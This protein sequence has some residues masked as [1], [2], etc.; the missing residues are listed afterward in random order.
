MRHH[1][2]PQELSPALEK[3]DEFIQQILANLHILDQS[4]HDEE[5][6]VN[7]SLLHQRLN[8]LGN[9]F[10]DI[11]FDEFAS[12]QKISQGQAHQTNEQLRI[13]EHAIVQKQRVIGE[14]R[15]EQA[16]ADQYMQQLQ[17]E[18]ESL[19]AKLGTSRS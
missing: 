18:I 14:L 2:T 8:Q 3:D 19:Q 9:R 15:V 10:V 4:P 1:N 17:R 7:L 5:A 6:M 13:A 16:S 12:R 11:T